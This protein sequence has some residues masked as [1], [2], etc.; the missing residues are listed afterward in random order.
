MTRLR[1]RAEDRLGVERHKRAHV[2]HLRVHAV[3]ALQDLGGLERARHHQRERDDRAVAASTQN[4]GRSERVDDLAIR[5][6]ALDRVERLVLVKDHWIRIA[7]RRS[8]QP[9]DVHWRRGRDNL[10]ARNHHRPVLDR[11][12]MLS[13]ETH[14]AAV[15][16]SDHQRARKLAVRHVSKLRHFIR[17]VV[18]AD[19][20]EIGEHELRDR[21]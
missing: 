2:D 5:H 16:G 7:H 19:C 15:A 9:D 13:A 11:L 6:F 14:P 12:R 17:D 10:H 8:H 20:E 4:F 1:D 18:E 3:V 21:P